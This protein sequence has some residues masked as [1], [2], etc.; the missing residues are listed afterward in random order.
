MSPEPEMLEPEIPEPEILEAIQ[1]SLE[2]PA[3]SPDLVTRLLTL[4]TVGLLAL[5]EVGSLISLA[6]AVEEGAWG[7][8]PRAVG[9]AA[10]AILTAVLAGGR[11]PVRY[12]I[13]LDE[14]YGYV[15]SIHRAAFFRPVRLRLSVYEEATRVHRVVF[16]WMPLLSG[17]RLFGLRGGRFEEMILGFWSFGRNGTQAVVLSGPGRPR[18]LV[19]PRDPGGF[20]RGLAKLLDVGQ[21]VTLDPTGSDSEHRGW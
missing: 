20:L 19:S 16:A 13:N 9:F 15:L 18:T 2:F 1:E 8:V 3:A 5:L 4:F 14:T 7:D 17:T 12:T 10:L 6:Q 11:V 21:A